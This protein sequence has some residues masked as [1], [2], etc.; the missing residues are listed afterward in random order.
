RLLAARRESHSAYRSWPTVGNS[1]LGGF[2]HGAAG[3]SYALVRLFEAT[4]DGR[5]LEAAR[6]GC[7]Y[8]DTLFDPEGGNWADLRDDGKDAIDQCSWCH[9]AAGIA[10]G[11][12]LSAR[13][14]GA[15]GPESHLEDALRRTLREPLLNLDQLCCGNL[16]RA[17]ILLEASRL[18]NR[19][20]YAT[21]AVR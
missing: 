16:G 5:Y 17:D 4:G 11:R 14:L 15:H 12:A 21:P 6:E 9:G 18:L 3:I 2:S 13:S 7:A 8:E 10:L 20:E 1:L 19:P